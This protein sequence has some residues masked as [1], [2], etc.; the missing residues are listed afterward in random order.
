MQELEE[1]LLSDLSN[2]GLVE[3][4]NLSLR[5]YSKSY[6]GRYDPNTNTVILYVDKTPEGDM[7][8]YQ[9]LLLTLIHEVIHCKQWSNPEFHRVK[10][11]MHDP[12]FKRLYNMYSN[13]VKAL[14]LFREVVVRCDCIFPQSL[15]QAH[16]ACSVYC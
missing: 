4:F 13:R 2:V 8:S 16:G 3:D 14:S 1:K 7:F 12:E 15:Y 5:G 11:V 6:F 10:G 9:D